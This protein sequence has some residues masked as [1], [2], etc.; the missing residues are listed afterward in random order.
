MTWSVALPRKLARWGLGRQLLL[1]GL[2]GEG[3]V[4][5][6]AL[7]A[8]SMGTWST[9]SPRKLARRGLG[10]QL[11]LTGLLTG[12]LLVTLSRLLA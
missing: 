11:R 5:N 4:S 3:L 1:D 9:D 8:Y 2:L 6:P 10:Q 7:L 12:I